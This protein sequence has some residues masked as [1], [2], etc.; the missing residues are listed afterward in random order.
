VVITGPTRN[1]LSWETGTVG[2]NPTLSAR[3]QLER[4][5]SWFVAMSHK[6]LSLCDIPTFIF[7]IQSGAGPERCPS[8]PK[9]H[10]WKSCVPNG[11]EGSN[12]SLSAKICEANFGEISPSAESGEADTPIL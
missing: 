6:D 4:D 11:T 9:G 1:R 7:F 8:W 5:Y 3:I 12:P 10:D 2:S